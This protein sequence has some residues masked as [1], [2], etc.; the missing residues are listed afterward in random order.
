ML[1]GISFSERDF[2]Q[3]QHQ[4]DQRWGR[5]VNF[6]V[7]LHVAIF[8]GALYLPY[9]FDQKPLLDE[10]MTIDL[11]SLP[12]LSKV[13][14]Q[15][16][17]PVVR[18]PTVAK[19]EP[20]PEPVATE[21]EPEEAIPLEA[22]PPAPE[23]APAPVVEDKPISVRPLKRK[24][25]KAKD[26]RLVEEK[27]RQQRA[28][29]LKRQQRA[30]E[31]KRQRIAR[32]NA[33]KKALANARNEEKSAQDAARRARAE[34]ASVIHEQETFRSAK[35]TTGGRSGNKRVN[36]AVEKQYYMDL[37]RRVQQ[38]W[39]LPEIKKWSP[40]LETRVEFTVLRDGRLIS[41]QI[42]HS[43]GDLFFDRFAL[44]TV[45][46]AAPMPPFPAVL[47]KERMDVGLRFRPGGVQ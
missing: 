9:L 5:A 26:I 27:Q 42:A 16:K 17:P 2:Y 34:L 19:P 36:S 44:E 35:P 20:K 13:T 3:Q 18:Q 10:V 25:R 8:A 14:A 23:P 21:P 4:H 41:I 29:E 15:A 40:T 32:E 6:A 46:K 1:D 31:L 12:N 43:S 22:V 24:I 28:D 37:A 33:R 47:R 45:R 7:V 11:V 30:D 38:L 39:V